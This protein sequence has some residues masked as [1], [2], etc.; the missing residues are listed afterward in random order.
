M[1]VAELANGPA[2]ID[3]REFMTRAGYDPARCTEATPLWVPPVYADA[4][5]AWP[6]SFAELPDTPIQLEA[7]SARGRIV[8]S[9]IFAPWNPQPASGVGVPGAALDS[10]SATI[11]SIVTLIIVPGRSTQA[12]CMAS[13]RT[14]KIF[15]V[16]STPT[17]P[18]RF[19]RRSGGRSAN[20]PNTPAT[21]A[22]TRRSS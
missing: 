8:Y 5:I 12:A 14:F 13:P 11:S 7:G 17:T 16:S 21:R 15:S 3:W 6:G 10:G 1:D 18:G 19:W 22:T 2:P 20:Y 4:R 9:R